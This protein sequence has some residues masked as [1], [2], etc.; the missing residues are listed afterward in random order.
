MAAL[1]TGTSG[2]P[3]RLQSQALPQLD[4]AQRANRLPVFRNRGTRP[5]NPMVPSPHSKRVLI[6]AYHYPPVGGSSGVQR[7]LKFSA[8][9]RDFGWEPMVLTVQPR[10]YELVTDGQMAEIPKDIVIE[11]AF[12]LDAARH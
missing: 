12:A 9:L 2:G 5:V 7:A 6:V 1:S 4:A 8:Y 10:A 11:R 3:E